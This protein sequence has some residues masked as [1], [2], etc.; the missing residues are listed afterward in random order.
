MMRQWRSKELFRSPP[1]F[2][3]FR[4]HR[5]QGH[6]VFR[7][8]ALGDGLRSDFA[9]F[10]GHTRVRVALL[11]LAFFPFRALFG[12]STRALF[13]SFLRPGVT[14][15]SLLFFFAFHG[16]RLALRAAYDIC[17][18][19]RRELL[20]FFRC[21]RGPG[22]R[23]YAAVRGV[24]FLFIGFARCGGR[25]R[26]SRCRSSDAVLACR[27]PRGAKDSQGGSLAVPTRAARLTVRRPQWL[28]LRSKTR[29]DRCG[30]PFECQRSSTPC[31]SARS[32]WCA[33]ITQSALPF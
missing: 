17:E 14:A 18:R 8:A 13:G 10:F 16:V 15:R 11:F 3:R 26:M 9:C 29:G 19:A 12:E 27:C 23:R 2:G 30:A 20:R 21:S 4:E 5:L 1:P 28:R 7:D 22:V 31:S 25:R 33:C 24:V 32:I 6:V